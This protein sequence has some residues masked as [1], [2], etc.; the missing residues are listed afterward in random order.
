MVLANESDRIATALQKYSDSVYRICF[1]YLGRRP[2]VDDVFQEVFLKLLQNQDSFADE[3]HEKAWL[4]RV[5]INKCKDVVKGFW[6][7][8]IDLMEEVDLPGHEA[9]E[10]DLL[11]VVLSLP[12]K[13][14]DVVYLHY[15]QDYTVPQMG[16]ILQ[17][18]ENTIYS[19]LHRARELMRKELEGKG[20]ERA[21]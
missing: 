2:E 4:I 1:I 5:A 19:Q 20:H 13:Y 11:R 8:R 3:E 16:Q 9:E 17:R 15:Y 7:R 6:W 12:Q 10:K 18:S 14:K 21:F